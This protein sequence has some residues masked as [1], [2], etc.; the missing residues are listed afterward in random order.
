MSS[1]ATFNHC[2]DAK[3]EEIDKKREK[4]VHHLMTFLNGMEDVEGEEI[5]KA[6]TKDWRERL[7]ENLPYRAED[8]MLVNI[9]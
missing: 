1:I 7:F 9:P 2:L 8:T 3:T 4:A 6:N 5:N